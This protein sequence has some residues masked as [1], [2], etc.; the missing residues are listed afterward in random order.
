MHTIKRDKYK[1]R[2]GGNSKILNIHC[3]NCDHIVITYQKDGPGNL[4]RL[5]LDRIISPDSFTDL[6]HTHIDNIPPLRCQNCDELIG[7]PYIYEKEQRPAYRV[8]AQKF[9]KRVQK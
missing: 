7:S 2:R 3:R 8:Y 5:Y 9:L 1:S 6:Q 4:R